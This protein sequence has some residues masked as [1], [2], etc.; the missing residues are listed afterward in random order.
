M[1]KH[2]VKGATNQ[3]TGKIKEAVGK[4][5]D[6]HSLRAKGVARDTK[7]KLQEKV[8]DA[9]E[10]QRIGFAHEVVTA[11]ELDTTVA[12]IAKGLVNNSPNAVMEAKKLV[13]EVVGAPVTDAL[14]ADTANRIAAIRAS[15]EGREGVASFLEKRKPSWLN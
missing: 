11:D 1:N 12:G 8:G 5:T 9:K 13:R 15:M 2:Q 3:V 6:D 14:L 7:G 4:A 10:A